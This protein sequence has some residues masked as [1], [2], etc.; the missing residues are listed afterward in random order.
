MLNEA[1]R[2]LRVFHDLSQK[3]LAA[4]LGV[5][6]SYVSE[7][8][9]G[10]KKPTLQLLE[11][12]AQVYGMPLSSIMFFAENL[13]KEGTAERARQFVSDKVLRLM[14]FIAERSGKQDDDEDQKLS[15]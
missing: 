5:T 11:R 6:K 3:D 9:A 4:K 1:L 10:K 8:E 12:Y 2:L 13:G 15:A 14:A 7:I